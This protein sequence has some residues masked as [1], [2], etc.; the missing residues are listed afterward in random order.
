MLSRITQLLAALDSDDAGF[1]PRE[2]YNQTWLLRLVL[3]WFY[4]HRNTDHALTPMPGARWYTDGLLRSPLASHQAGAGTDALTHADGLL[5]H[6]DLLPDT[7]G[8][9]T[10]RPDVQQFIVVEGTLGDH[11][12]AGTAHIADDDQA[13]HIIAAVAD[14]LA[15]AGRRPQ[16]VSQLSFFVFAS[17]E[18]INAGA[19]G[20]LLTRESIRERV[21]AMSQVG[22]SSGEGD[23]ESA[24][25]EQ[26]LAES[27][28]PALGRIDLELYSWEAILGHIDLRDP[29][30]KLEEFYKR[31]L[32]FNP[33]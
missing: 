16:R 31:C 22:P 11:L 13:A 30:S 8:E 20:H 1:S 28:E 12:S 7:H 24:V 6:F 25:T 19:F 2:I 21:R 10:L 17:R 29:E 3:D 9:A 18:R 15:P 4:R 27:F 33:A 14:M 5:G 26:W 23:E 32:E